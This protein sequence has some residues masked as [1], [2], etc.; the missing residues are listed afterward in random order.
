L[1]SI[2]M[3]QGMGIQWASTLLGCIAAA[4]IPIPIIFY[5]YGHKIRA[6]SSF[7]PTGMPMGMQRP[8]AS[9]SADDTEE[10]AAGEQEKSPGD[11]AAGANA[12]KKD[13]QAAGNGV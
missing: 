11:S 13:G 2:Y 8:A 10:T 9:A 3:F 7:A 4:L 1:F 6:R 5:L 12:P